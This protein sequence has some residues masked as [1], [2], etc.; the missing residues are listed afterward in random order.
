MNG[1]GFMPCHNNKHNMGRYLEVSLLMLLYH[2][3][4][5]GYKLKEELKDFGFQVDELNIGS[6]YKV[7]RK[8]EDKGSVSSRWKKGGP[9]PKRRVYE[10]TH[11][12]KEELDEWIAFL[13]TRKRKIDT[14][15]RQYEI[16]IHHDDGV[17]NE[18]DEKHSSSKHNKRKD[19]TT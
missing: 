19:K 2:T 9:G 16:T 1:R 6:L 8:L 18:N 17:D 12:G 13:K 3:T 14:L 11:E 4:G 5:Y 7:L 10:I 15:I